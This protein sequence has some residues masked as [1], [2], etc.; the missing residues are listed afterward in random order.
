MTTIEING[1][2]Y[3][4]SIE[5]MLKTL[6][7][8]MWEEPYSKDSEMAETEEEFREKIENFK[9]EIEKLESTIEGLIKTNVQLTKKNVFHKTK[10][11]ILLISDVVTSFSDEYNYS[12]DK[13]CLKLE[14]TSDTTATLVI[15][16]ANFQE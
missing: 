16:E 13:I 4:Y 1:I 5:A 9:L 14:K 7:S 2:K 6:D 8:Y 12:W 11:Y 10:R 3:S 15:D